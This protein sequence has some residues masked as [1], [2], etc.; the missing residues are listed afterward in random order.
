MQSI[1][2][3]L[4]TELMLLPMSLRRD[5]LEF[6]GGTPV[7]DAQLRQILA[8]LSARNAAAGCD[9]RSQSAE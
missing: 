9:A 6:I 7:E 8:D 1:H 4:F 2:P 5:L 3:N